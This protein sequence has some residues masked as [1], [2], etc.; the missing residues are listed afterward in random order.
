[1]QVRYT[2]CLKD[3]KK[4]QSRTAQI[5]WQVFPGDSGMIEF[6]GLPIGYTTYRQGGMKVNG[7]KLGNF[8]YI[9]DIRDHREEIFAFLEGTEQLVLSALRAEASPRPFFVKRRRR[10]LPTKLA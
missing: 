1:M 2:I 8:A 3:M 10:C 6:A 4:G 7:F 5:D 9:S